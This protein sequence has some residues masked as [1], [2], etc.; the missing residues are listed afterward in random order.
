MWT[1]RIGFKSQSGWEKSH[2]GGFTRVITDYPYVKKSEDVEVSTSDK[3]KGLS[4]YQGDKLLKI[5]M[6]CVKEHNAMDAI[7]TGAAKKPALKSKWTGAGFTP[8]PVTEYHTTPIGMKAALNIVLSRETELA[9]LFNEYREFIVGSSYKVTLEDEPEG[10]EGGEGKEGEGEGEGKGESNVKTKDSKEGESD[11]SGKEGK[12]SDGKGGSGGNGGKAASSEA[13]SV[14]QEE[15]EQRR[16]AKPK[17]MTPAELKAVLEELKR[18]MEE[19]SKSSP[20]SSKRSS[21]GTGSLAGGDWKPQFVPI[22]KSSKETLISPL[23][24]KNGEI[25]LK[26]LDITWDTDKDIVKSLRLGK[27]DISKIAEVPAGNVAVYQRE[28]EEQSTKPFSICVLM[29]ESGSMGGWHGGDEDNPH[30]HC[31]RYTSMYRLIKSL[32]VAFSQLLPPDKLFIYGHS[33]DDTPEIY[34]YHDPYNPNFLH[35]V[36]DMMGRYTQQ[37]Y[38]GPVIEA[39]HKKVRE[40]TDDRIIFIVLSDGNPAGNGYG[41]YDDVVDLKRIVEAARR[42]EFV[43]VGVGIQYSGVD[44]Y[45]YSTVVNNLND[46]PKKVSH[47][48]NKVVKTE[49][50]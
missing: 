42:D 37:N 4:W 15:I 36:D 40:I 50:Q 30:E 25:L 7:F 11:G 29:D 23:Q 13:P 9:P 1:P 22:K 6:L 35:T 12:P 48:L 46:M 26:M 18:K 14:S 47:I 45:T 2:F 17:E 43:T 31:T 39:V 33:G 28:M 44:L 19:T 8:V 32:Y 27:I 3:N 38:D 5:F 10:S 16:D 49:F 21:G 34:T 24:I 20:F 41:G